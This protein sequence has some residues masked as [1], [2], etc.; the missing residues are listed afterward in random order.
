MTTSY[1]DTA[2][3]LVQNRF[4][5]LKSYAD[6]AFNLTQNYIEELTLSL[7]NIELPDSSALSAVNI[8]EYT[9][10]NYRARPTLGQ[11]IFTTT[12]ATAPEDIVDFNDLTSFQVDSIVDIF[13]TNT[14]SEPSA[15]CKNTSQAPVLTTPI[16]PEDVSLN[17]V[18]KPSAPI[19]YMPD[20]PR[21]ATITLPNKI[22]IDLGQFNAISPG[23]LD[24]SDPV[25]MTYTA[26]NYSSEL[27]KTLIDL[28]AQGFAS[29]EVYNQ[30]VIDS[31]TE[32]LDVIIKKLLDIGSS[33]IN[34]DVEILIYDRGKARLKTEN[35]A[36]YQQV[37]NEF[38]AKGFNL[39]NGIFA[40]NIARVQREIADKNDRLNYEIIVNQVN[41][42]QENRKLMIEKAVQLEGMFLTFFNDTENRTLEAAKAVAANGIEVLKARIEAYNAQLDLYKTEALVFE[43]KTKAELNAIEIYKAQ[44]QGAA[45]ESEI[46]KN[47]IDLYT[48]QVE[49]QKV[50][51]E[52]YK[53][54]MEGASI[55][56]EIE[57]LK[58][59]QLEVRTKIYLAEIEA[60]KTKVEIYKEQN[61]AEKIRLEGYL[62]EIDVYK[63]KVSVEKE[64][65]DAHF[66]AKKLL[67]QE[68][69]NLIEKYKASISAYTA[70][71]QANDNLNEKELR[72]FQAMVSAYEA[73]TDS[74]KA[75]NLMKIEEAK[76]KIQEAQI[77]L[78][79]IKSELNITLQGFLGIKELQIKGVE[80]I[81]N[82]G[83][84]LAASAMNAANASASYTF[85]SSSSGSWY[86]HPD[87]SVSESTNY[88][89]S[90]SI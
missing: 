28:I 69:V 82:A 4:D 75:E 27:S 74:D 29:A 50:I 72:A 37:C 13:E 83:A 64:K 61:N 49:A 12:T 77:N 23:E 42:A 65:L 24:L 58:I 89:Y 19:T 52:I 17:T 56:M 54:Q 34:G 57:N 55:S 33:G 87:V 35:E 88:N 73:E 31:S 7:G 2:Q 66:E 81:V 10:L 25:L 68:N 53:V 48:R 40:S 11:G 39:P 60:E 41:L 76:V 67:L 44:L 38:G 79:K 9:S 21:L 20:V 16:K 22:S 43:T 14:T 71:L 84:Q 30:L 8:P 62:A 32:S 59:Q 63:T 86:Y 85:G 70:E 46:Q 80:G 45:I 51:V 90:G 47:E 15:F 5:D 36:M 78:E 6:S 18:S 3:G 26:K 1:E